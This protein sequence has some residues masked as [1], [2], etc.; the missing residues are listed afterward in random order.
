MI[1]VAY[2]PTNQDSTEE[3]DQ[4]YEDLNCIVTRGNGQVMVMG[5]F[6]AL[7]S[8]KLHGVVGPHGLETTTSD[9]GERPV[10]FACASSMCLTN[11]FFA[12]KNIHQVTWHSSDPSKTPSLKDCILVKQRMMSSVLD[13]RAYDRGDIDSDHRLVIISIHLR[14]RKKPKEKRVGSLT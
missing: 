1:V 7:V 14:L 11:T 5:N 8:E 13:T 9:N 6:N 3:K 2:A 12:H 10:S 4:F